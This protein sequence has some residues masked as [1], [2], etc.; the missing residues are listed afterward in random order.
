MNGTESQ[1]IWQ[2]R[3]AA[4][5]IIDEFYSQECNSM[6]L[7][8]REIITGAAIGIGAILTLILGVAGVKFYSDLNSAETKIKEAN[9]RIDALESEL[10]KT[11]SSFRVSLYIHFSVCLEVLQSRFT[12]LSTN[13]WSYNN[14]FP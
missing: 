14:F 7:A 1:Q 12:F 5:N 9:L 6:G 10:A 11:N 2:A 13:L 4:E 8:K 3:K